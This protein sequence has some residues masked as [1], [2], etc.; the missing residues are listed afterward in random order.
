M[1][2]SDW[3]SLGITF[4]VDGRSSLAC[5]CLNI[6]HMPR[7]LFDEKLY[8]IKCRTIYHLFPGCGRTR[9]SPFSLRFRSFSWRLLVVDLSG[10]SSANGCDVERPRTIG[11]ITDDHSL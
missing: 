7:L 6:I 5:H 8:N 1:A 2:R 3:N 9:E 11:E 10:V 4:D